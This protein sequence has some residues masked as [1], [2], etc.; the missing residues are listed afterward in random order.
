MSRRSVDRRRA[1]QD[2]QQR[3]WGDP[4]KENASFRVQPD[5]ALRGIAE[6]AET[7]VGCCRRGGPALAERPIA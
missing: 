2:I 6:P 3:R 4:R 7:D 5:E 1:R